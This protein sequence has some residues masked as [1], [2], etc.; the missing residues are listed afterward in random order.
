MT[1]IK[2]LAMSIAHHI[3]LAIVLPL[4]NEE[5]T[6]DE[7]LARIVTYLSPQ[8]RVFCVVDKASKDDTREKVDLFA[9]R[10][11]RITTVWAPENRCVVDAYFRGYSTAL[12]S[13]ATWILEM[14]GGLSHQPEDIPRFME[15][16]G[17]N[18]DYVAGCRFM[19]GGSH[20]GAVWRRFLSWGGSNLANLLLNTRMRD[21]TSG[22]EMFSRRAMQHVVTAGVRSRAHF[23]QTEI[24]H[25]LRDWRWVEVP[26]RYHAT[27]SR[28]PMGSITE[29]LRLLWQ[30]HQEGRRAP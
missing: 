10:D 9:E 28:V 19:P 4:A 30:M 16:I 15:H 22:F 3:R 26:I 27:S 29:S 11:P 20:T 23:F 8:D 6:V 1:G 5:D 25:L 18:F 17:G 12:D 13:G 24:K 14:D 21:M 7:L 2:R